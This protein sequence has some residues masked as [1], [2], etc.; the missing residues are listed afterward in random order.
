MQDNDHCEK[1]TLITTSTVMSCRLAI[2]IQGRDLGLALNSAM[3]T[4]AQGSVAM[5]QKVQRILEIIRQENIAGN[6][7]KH[8]SDSLKAVH[9]LGS[10]EKERNTKNTHR[11]AVTRAENPNQLPHQGA[12]QG[13][14][15]FPSLYAASCRPLTKQAQ[16]ILKQMGGSFLFLA[17]DISELQN[18]LLQDFVDA[19]FSHATNREIN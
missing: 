10:P 16:N 17:Q 15:L 19:T 2:S 6:V 12:E 18:S 11:K 13:M 3:E 5:S 8:C 14:R 1:T 7:I 4:I 9:S